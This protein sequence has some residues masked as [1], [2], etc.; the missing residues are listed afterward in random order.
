M[1]C[2]WPNRQRCWRRVEVGGCCKTLLC[3]ARWVR[4]LVYLSIGSLAPRCCRFDSLE[5]PPFGWRLLRRE[6]R[7]TLPPELALGKFWCSKPLQGTRT[8]QRCQRGGNSPVS[9]WLVLCRSVLPFHQSGFPCSRRFAICRHSA[10]LLT[11]QCVCTLWRW[12]R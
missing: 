6:R 2:N 10:L 3:K 7:K 8:L 11:V 5:S 12:S 1:L 4:P 9:H